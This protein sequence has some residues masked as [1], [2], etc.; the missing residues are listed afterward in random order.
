MWRGMDTPSFVRSLALS[1]IHQ[2]E[3]LMYPRISI[4][5]TALVLFTAC[6]GGAE[7]K[8]AQPAADLVIGGEQSAVA[9]LYQ[10]PTPNELFGLVRQMAGEGHKRMLNPAL[11]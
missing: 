5:L 9:S 2:P 6:G 11:R 8:T 3:F 7:E 10:M 1:A 4:P